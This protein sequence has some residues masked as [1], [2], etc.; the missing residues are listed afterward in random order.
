MS[1]R[2]TISK[3]REPLAC[4]TLTKTGGLAW[5]LPCPPLMEGGSGQ[6]RA[7]FTTLGGCSADSL[8][9][10]FTKPLRG[11]GPTS[12]RRP[13]SEGHFDCSTAPH[14]PRASRGWGLSR[15][16]CWQLWAPTAK[17]KRRPGEPEASSC[18][19]QAFPGGLWSRGRGGVTPGR[20]ATRS[21]CWASSPPSPGLPGC[22]FL[23][24]CPQMSQQLRRKLIKNKSHLML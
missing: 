3:G 7:A 14:T 5:W 18:W 24:L 9:Q 22:R 10:G 4:L 16:L 13:G 11:V 8:N 17:L 20:P 1:Q 15:P 23:S 2:I 19:A 12:C 6:G 21:S